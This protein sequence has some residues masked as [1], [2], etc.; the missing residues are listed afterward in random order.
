MHS[1]RHALSSDGERTALYVHAPGL[2]KCAGQ[3]PITQLA[4]PAPARFH[5]QNLDSRHRKD[6]FLHPGLMDSPH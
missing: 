2:T 6:F 5:A 4:Q 3:A 1:Q